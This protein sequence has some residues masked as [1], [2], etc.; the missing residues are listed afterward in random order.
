MLNGICS[1]SER[2]DKHCKNSGKWLMESG[3]NRKMIRKQI[4]RAR[5]H[6]RKDFLE[7]EKTET[8]N[9]KLT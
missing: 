1:D 4:L 2:L 6:S 7:R 3:Y 5:E 9:P 8:S